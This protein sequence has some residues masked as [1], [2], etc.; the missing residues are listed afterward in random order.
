MLRTTFLHVFMAFV[1]SGSI[2]SAELRVPQDHQDL[3]SAINA[4]N[5]GDQILLDTGK[6]SGPGFREIVVP[7]NMHIVISTV[8]G[9]QF[10]VI[11]CE[12]YNFVVID[13]PYGTG[14]PIE[15]IGLTIRNADTCVRVSS[16]GSVRAYN[17]RFVQCTFGLIDRSSGFNFVEFDSCLFQG[18]FHGVEVW[19][20]SWASISNSMFWGNG[21]GV[22][23]YHPAEGT[24]SG[25]LIVHNGDG[26]V[27]DV[28]G[29]NYPI[30]GNVIVMNGNG[31]SLFNDNTFGY[32][33]QFHG[34]NIWGNNANFSGIPNLTGLNCNI[35]SNPFLCDTSSFPM[36]I[37]SI[38][39][40]LPQNN[41]CGISIGPPYILAC[42]CGDVDVSG[43]VDIGDISA[44]ISFLYLNGPAPTSPA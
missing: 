19:G 21:E 34:N 3:Q 17:C 15:F 40:L 18:N 28:L 41:D 12:N 33:T 39:P 23:W 10:T 44:I 31:V 32:E 42:Y 7:P 2:F 26:V 38:A 1:L 36:L 6:F 9:P 27:M 22:D 13:D 29:L 25:N 20:D 14:T 37:A 16:Y 30:S 35:S 5:S 4:C 8:L 43:N 11:N 24:L